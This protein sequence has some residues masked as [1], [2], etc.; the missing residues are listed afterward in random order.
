MF[1]N[2]HY[3]FIVFLGIGIVLIT[4]IL[5]VFARFDFIKRTHNLVK[6]TDEKCE[7]KK[8]CQFYDKKIY[9][10]Y[11]NKQI[12][13]KSAERKWKMNKLKTIKDPQ[14][15]EYNL[16]AD[17]EEEKAKIAKWDSSF[18]EMVDTWCNATMNS[19]ARIYFEP[20]ALLECKLDFELRAIS[21]LDHLYYY[22]IMV[23]IPGSKGVRGFEPSR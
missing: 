16:F 7:F 1:K 2:K 8:T 14:I 17:L 18:E 13:I 9:L 20:S 3:K 21:E 15:W 10:E 19:F 11:L 23:E 6:V 4:I 5:A 22:N 12:V